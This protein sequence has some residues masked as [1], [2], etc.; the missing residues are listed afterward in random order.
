MRILEKS[1]KVYDLRRSADWSGRKVWDSWTTFLRNIFV[2]LWNHATPWMVKTSA[3]SSHHCIRALFRGQ[4]ISFLSGHLHVC[5]PVWI[6]PF[7]IMLWII[8]IQLTLLFPKLAFCCWFHGQTCPGSRDSR[9][10]YWGQCNAQRSGP[11]DYWLLEHAHLLNLSSSQN[12]I[13]GRKF[14]SYD[15]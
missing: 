10:S 15:S 1:G 14:L 3:A 11:T 2:V 7:V 5:N 6:I 9:A 12:H 4:L 8:R 13:N